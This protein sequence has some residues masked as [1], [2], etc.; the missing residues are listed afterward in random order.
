MCEY[1][2]LDDRDEQFAAGINALVDGLEWAQ[3]PT[4]PPS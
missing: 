2:W 3:Y 4:P 1:V